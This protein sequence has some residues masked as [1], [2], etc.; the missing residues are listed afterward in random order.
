MLIH[1]VKMLIHCVTWLRI[2]QERKH[3]EINVD[4]VLLSSEQ[5]REIADGDADDNNNNN[6]GGIICKEWR[7]IDAKSGTEL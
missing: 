6:N 3:W 1:S 5:I 4:R 7:R 2:M